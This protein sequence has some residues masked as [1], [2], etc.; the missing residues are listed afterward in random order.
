MSS[1]SDVGV[2]TRS[3]RSSTRSSSSRQPTWRSPSFIRTSAPAPSASVSIVFAE[4]EQGAP[5]ARASAR[6]PISSSPLSVREVRREEEED[7]EDGEEDPRRV[8]NDTHHSKWYN[9]LT[10]S[11]GKS[12]MRQP[13]IDEPPPPMPVARPVPEDTD[14]PGSP[15][16]STPEEPAALVVPSTPPPT[17]P[18]N[19]DPD[20]DLTERPPIYTASRSTPPSSLDERVPSL[21]PTPVKSTFTP[22][23]PP[24]G[25]TT[26]LNPSSSRFTLSI[27]LLG[28]P[29]VPLGS[30]LGKDNDKGN[31]EIAVE[32]SA[33]NG[34]TLAGTVEVQNPMGD[35][36]GGVGVLSDKDDSTS[37]PGSGD[38]A[39]AQMSSPAAPS[40]S[41][42]STPATSTMTET[43]ATTT[44]ITIMA[45][46]TETET[47]TER[48]TA[49]AIPPTITT[50]ADSNP[51]ESASN[52]TMTT[53]WWNYVGWGSSISGTVAGEVSGSEPVVEAA[54]GQTKEGEDAEGGVELDVPKEEGVASEGGGGGGEERDVPVP[55][56]GDSGST[57]PVPAPPPTTSATTTT[58]WLTPWTW[59]Y[60]PATDLHNVES[61]KGNHPAEEEEEHCHGDGDDLQRDSRLEAGLSTTTT[62][63]H[64]PVPPQPSV[65]DTGN[66]IASTITSHTSSWASFFSSRSLMVKTL[67]YGN[68][69]LIEDVRRDENGVEVMELDLDE[70]GDNVPPAEESGRGRDLQPKLDDVVGASGRF[71]A[72]ARDVRKAKGKVGSLAMVLGVG[73]L[74]TDK[75]TDPK[76]VASSSSTPP[77]PKKGNSGTST[78]ALGP[79]PSTSASNK[80]PIPIS[81]S[82]S[83]QTPTKPDSSGA[84]TPTTTT[85]APTS[86]PKPQPPSKSRTSSPAPSSKRSTSVSTPA[87]PPPPNLVLPTWHDIFHTAP[88]NVLL[89]DTE[90]GHGNWDGVGAKVLGKTM[91]FVSGVFWGGEGGSGGTMRGKEK[92]KE[93]E[94]V[95]VREGSVDTLRGTGGD[96]E[97]LLERDRRERFREFG[98][99]L[100]KAWRVVEEGVR[101]SHASGSKSKSGSRLLSTLS[102]A[103]S[104]P[105]SSATAPTAAKGKGKR[106]EDWHDE[107]HRDDGNEAG[108]HDVLRGCRRVV[109]IGVHG[110]FPGAMIRSVLG[111]PTGTS[112]K[113]ANMTE[114]ALLEFED[115]HGVKFD[116]ITKVP[117][118]GD[119]T[120]ER[121]VERLYTNLKA[122]PE[123]MSDLH[124]ADAIIVSTHSQGSIVSTHLLDRLIRDGYI[125]TLRSDQEG[126]VSSG[127]DQN[128]ERLGMTMPVPLG[129]GA[130]VFPSS[131]SFSCGGEEDTTTT[132]KKKRKVQRVCCLAL[133]GIHLGP[134]RY[135]SSSTLVGPYLQYFESTAARELFEF[136]NTE[137]AVSKAYV[138]ALR[139]VLDHGTKIL[140]VAS[141]NDQVVP[142][143]SGLFTAAS[144]PLIL[145]AL[146]IDGDAYHSSDFLSNLLV[147][148]LRIL[149]SGIPDSGL[150]AH[151]SEAT[152]GSL[153]GVGHSTA[154]EELATYRLAVNYL[155]LANEGLPSHSPTPLTIEPFNATQEQNDYEIPW[156]LRDIIADERVAF[157]FGREIVKLRDEFR[158]WG[159][160]TAVLR[161]LKRKLQP[162]TRLPVG[163]LEGVGVG[164]GSKL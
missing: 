43:V 48:D 115:A 2:P 64:Q 162:I 67:G 131:I 44:P 113:F 78:P 57:T 73:D 108:L 55:E 111:E 144:H 89:P 152:A 7:G 88:R 51:P 104:S 122:N 69:G 18:L 32:Q 52:T 158:E 30:V 153:N 157:F 125:V 54:Q 9:S 130:G 79:S 150:I 25:Q 71:K 160:R 86:I 92:G 147:L 156:S 161:D 42:S 91:K 5:L 121:R 140:Y 1:S 56:E 70:A 119:G 117:L 100:P 63:D 3:R 29:K 12:A 76:A 109:V 123:W 17:Y 58:T 128:S 39:D 50:A 26:A 94:R 116:K 36:K 163:F 33:V 159:P 101:V 75:K 15:Q 134:L 65:Y 45:T 16:P 80:Q 87:P 46:E 85:K 13:E 6:I 4:P 132:K 35:G 145:R 72:D 126:E 107:G 23:T 90:A 137:S 61:E 138:A 151:L 8:G 154:Y 139:N 31:M 164:A 114:Q 155:F 143:Y 19:I 37:S 84:A 103:S 22:P 110:W 53:T 38:V 118:E 97:S 11:K 40:A 62:N 148:L 34:G 146:Y 95:G 99:E 60:S 20:P 105:S 83:T 27:P 41:T 77:T 102:S 98:K 81:P 66:P 10:R 120:I 141:L 142:I 135:L 129:V 133:C 127:E 112:S 68:A 24:L 14:K 96:G 149:N 82:T 47:E 136:Q 21:P 49:P 28:R 106:S 59:Y 74:K 124:D 93:R